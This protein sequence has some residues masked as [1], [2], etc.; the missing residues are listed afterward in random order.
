MRISSVKRLRD[1]RRK[2]KAEWQLGKMTV[3]CVGGGAAQA[4]AHPSVLK[5][6]QGRYGTDSGLAELSM[7]GLENVQCDM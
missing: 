1:K 4:R 5:R 7:N 3:Q 6:K 2:E